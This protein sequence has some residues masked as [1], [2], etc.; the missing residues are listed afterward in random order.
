MTVDELFSSESEQLYVR[1]IA[2]RNALNAANDNETRQV[3][4]EILDDTL[5]NLSRIGTDEEIAAAEEIVV[6]KSNKN[7][8]DYLTC[9]KFNLI[10]SAVAFVAI[11]AS[12]L[13]LIL[14]I[15][16]ANNSKVQA[17]ITVIIIGAG[18]SAMALFVASYMK[19]RMLAAKEQLKGKTVIGCRIDTEVKSTAPAS[20]ST[21]SKPKA[22]AAASTTSAGRAKP[23]R[24]HTAKARKQKG[25][26]VVRNYFGF[27][28]VL[29][30][31][32]IV[33]VLG[34]F[35]YTNWAKIESSIKNIMYNI[36]LTDPAPKADVER[37]KQL[38]AKLVD[39][40]N[41]VYYNEADKLYEEAKELA[42]KSDIKAASAKYDEAAEIFNKCILHKDAE[43][44]R[45]RAKNFE[46]Y[47]QAQVDVEQSMLKALSTLNKIVPTK[48]EFDY[49]GRVIK[50]TEKYSSYTSL[51]DT[52]EG[53][54]ERFS[55]KDFAMKDSA[56]SIQKERMGWKKVEAKVDREGYKYEIIEKKGDTVIKW[57]I[58][59]EYVLK[60]TDD[61]EVTLKR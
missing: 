10:A 35:V 51:V 15:V 26:K 20:S 45:T 30:P 7:V 61:G 50:L 47:Y 29:I 40:K 25:P 56:L 2:A 27:L 24:E 60:V 19:K 23:E 38:N 9:Q 44:R 22:A 42:K 53:G 36:G 21:S 16:G 28:K 3:L 1:L 54:G 39:V 31:L 59:D 17:I 43:E 57:Y 37:F 49:A 5:N 18:I 55:I 12:V 58:S 6:R 46:Y 41:S 8:K 11:V 4:N 13:A 14:I 33:A 32:A 48:P 52:Y 34:F